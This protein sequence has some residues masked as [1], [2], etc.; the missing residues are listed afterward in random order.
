MTFVRLEPITFNIKYKIQTINQ[1][2]YFFYLFSCIGAQYR[3]HASHATH[4][5]QM[6]I[7]HHM[8]VRHPPIRHMHVSTYIKRGKGTIKASG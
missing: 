3:C 5:H 1:H 2:S 8:H 6:A 7:A 4:E